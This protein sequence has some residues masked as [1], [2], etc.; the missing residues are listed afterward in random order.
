[1]DRKGKEW[2]QIDRRII[3]WIKI[4]GKNNREIVERV[5][6]QR[7]DYFWHKAHKKPRKK[8][9]GRDSTVNSIRRQTSLC[10]FISLE[11][12]L[13][14]VVKGLKYLFH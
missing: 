11:N 13:Y 7:R 14:W 9:K 1:M 5:E 6:K 8:T 4:G 10:G 3:E 2:S 12:D